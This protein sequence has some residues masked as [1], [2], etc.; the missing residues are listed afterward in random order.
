MMWCCTERTSARARKTGAAAEVEA[1]SNTMRLTIIS[2]NNFPFEEEQGS[3]SSAVATHGMIAGMLLSMS[4][5][6][7]M[8]FNDRVT[9]VQPQYKEQCMHVAVVD[10][11]SLS[12]TSEDVGAVDT[13]VCIPATHPGWQEVAIQEVDWTT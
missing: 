2:D 5:A 6:W 9:R 4:E 1:F 3:I 12:L 7:R 11:S 13:W 8:A 10:D